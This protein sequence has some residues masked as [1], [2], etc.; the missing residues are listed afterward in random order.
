MAVFGF[1]CSLGGR[2]RFFPPYKIDWEKYAETPWQKKQIQE[3]IQKI[4]AH[5]R[6][7]AR[8]NPIQMSCVDL[9]KRSLVR[10]YLAL[11]DGS[12]TGK[13]LY[14]AHLSLTVHDEIMIEC[15]EEHAEAVAN[16][17]RTHMLGVY[18]E[19]IKSVAHGPLEVTISDNY[20]GR[21]IPVETVLQGEKISNVGQNK[22]PF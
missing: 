19:L 14:D 8:N 17:M 6:R 20:A 3:E 4:Q 9:L 2:K 5:K 15:K 22:N 1:V 13:K 7:Q 10:I 11:R 18:N 16:L 12:W 21:N